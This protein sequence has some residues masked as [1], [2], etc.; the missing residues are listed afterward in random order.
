MK[1]AVRARWTAS[2]GTSQESETGGTAPK[3][4]A[5]TATAP[6]ALRAPAAVLAVAFSNCRVAESYLV[7]RG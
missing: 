4:A 2:S 6:T 1:P 7:E 5:S 3:E